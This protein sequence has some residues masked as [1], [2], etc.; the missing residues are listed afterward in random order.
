MVVFNLKWGQMRSRAAPGTG[1]KNQDMKG[2][3][4]VHVDKPPVKSIQC[5]SARTGDNVT[6]RTDKLGNVDV[7]IHEHIN[8]LSGVGWPVYTGPVNQQVAVALDQLIWPQVQTAK[9]ITDLDPYSR[10]IH[11]ALMAGRK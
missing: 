8:A 11:D 7:V 4:M 1:H 10:L 5:G 3:A 9:L 2:Y 6:Y